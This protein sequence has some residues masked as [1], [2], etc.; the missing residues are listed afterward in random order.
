MPRIGRPRLTAAVVRERIE[1]YCARYDAQL[2]AE[3]FPAYPAGRRETP[4]HREWVALY[5]A[6]QRVRDRAT[7]GSAGLPRECPIC[8]QQNDRRDAMHPR[9]AK[10]VA[11]VRELGSTALERIRA[12]AFPDDS[13]PV[14]APQDTVSRQA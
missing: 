6:F 11:F 10:L 8:L 7:P 14:V 1:G 5:K 13:G 9:C 12:R 3:G 4:Q 2:N